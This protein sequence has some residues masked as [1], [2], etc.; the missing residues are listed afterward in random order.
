MR[1]R[2]ILGKELDEVREKI[3]CPQLGDEN[4]GA[5]G[6]LRLEQRFTIFRLIRTIQHQKEDIDRLFRLRVSE[7][8]AEAIKEF[9]ERLLNNYATYRLT[10]E[11]SVD[12]VASDIKHLVKE[13]TEGE[14]RKAVRNNE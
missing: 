5:W 4:Y 2:L 6:S 8:K 3:S 9:A 11:I 12:A 14:Q 10:D 13:M 1:E 7:V